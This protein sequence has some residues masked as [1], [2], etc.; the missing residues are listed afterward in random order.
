MH[1]TAAREPMPLWLGKIGRGPQHVSRES[2]ARGDGTRALTRPCSAHDAQSSLVTTPGTDPWP[3]AILAGA[4]LLGLA[5][6]VLMPPMLTPDARA[7][8]ARAVQVSEGG[9]V[10]QKLG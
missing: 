10:A 6:C 7:H 1:I 2:R 5:L 8:W 4:L 3:R 9:L